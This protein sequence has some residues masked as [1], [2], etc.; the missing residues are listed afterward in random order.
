[1]N[2][3]YNSFCNFCDIN[4]CREWSII[5][6][7]VA[8]LTPQSLQIARAARN[9]MPSSGRVAVR[10]EEKMVAATASDLGLKIPRAAAMCWKDPRAYGQTAHLTP[11]EDNCC[12]ACPR[13]SP[14]VRLVAERRAGHTD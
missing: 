1:M 3:L 8:R 11:T 14:P 12:Q 13:K 4:L 9:T 5:L 6:F 10:K 7:A 2:V